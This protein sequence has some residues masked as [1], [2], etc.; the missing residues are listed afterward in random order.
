MTETI[1]RQWCPSENEAGTRCCY[2][3]GHE[4]ECSFKP[5]RLTEPQ[6]AA[7][8]EIGRFAVRQF[9]AIDRGK[10]AAVKALIRR[11]LARGRWVTSR[12]WDV[13]LT[14]AGRRVLETLPR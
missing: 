5:I 8:E 9:V 12:A 7:L 14:P 3:P 2:G 1:D 11:G 4:G 6:R 10:V 13:A